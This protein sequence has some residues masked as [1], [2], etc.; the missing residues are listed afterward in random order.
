MTQRIDYADILALSIDDR[1]ALV[2]AIWDSIAD[3][4][5][6]LPVPRGAAAAS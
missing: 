3:E 4:T 2:Q 1:I 5:G 6:A